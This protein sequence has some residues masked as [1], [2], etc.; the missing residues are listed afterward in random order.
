VTDL[1]RQ[2]ASRNRELE[3]T[4]GELA[5]ANERMTRDL[6]RA[7]QIQA[8]FRPAP[9]LE[10]PGGRATWGVLAAGSPGGVSP[11][12]FQLGERHLGVCVMD[13]GHHGADAALLTAAT[14]VLLCRSTADPA[15]PADVLGRLAERFPRGVTGDNPLALLYG[16]L[17][18]DGVFHFASAGHPGPVH[19]PAGG[20]PAPLEGAG[21]PLGVGAGGYADREVQLRVGDRLVIYTDGLTSAPNVEGE[22]FGV[23]RL[24][25]A[26]TPAADCTE[27]LRLVRRWQDD[28]PASRDVAVLTLERVDP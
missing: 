4:A 13:A 28:R 23:H 17:G 2:L 6:I 12:A 18:P 22:H 21:L 1:E 3:G 26:L 10:V 15:R 16:V 11:R 25:E 27:L 5:A 8:A 20:T 24:L 9:P 14:E 7:G 19:V